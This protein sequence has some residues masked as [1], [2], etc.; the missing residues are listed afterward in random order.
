MSPFIQEQEM[1]ALPQIRAS[2]DA[3]VKGGEY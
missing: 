3:N 2:V 1:G